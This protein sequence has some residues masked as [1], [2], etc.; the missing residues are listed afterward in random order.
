M[1]DTITGKE[2]AAHATPHVCRGMAL[3]KDGGT[4]AAAFDTGVKTVHAVRLVAGAA[5]QRSY[6]R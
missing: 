3:S 1:W 2:L 4:V 6:A 5:R